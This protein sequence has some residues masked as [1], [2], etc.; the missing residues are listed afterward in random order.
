MNVRALLRP[1]FVHA[2][3]SISPLS[4]IP[5]L[6]MLSV[7]FHHVIR[8]VPFHLPPFSLLYFRRGPTISVSTR[9]SNLHSHVRAVPFFP[10]IFTRYL[11]ATT[12]YIC[13]L[14]SRTVCNLLPVPLCFSPYFFFFSLTFAIDVQNAIILHVSPCVTC[15][16]PPYICSPLI[17]S[18]HIDAQITSTCV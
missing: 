17:T 2:S 1:T 14:H 10:F 15:Y 8:L 9:F 16:F 18:S 13:S 11:R 6:L 4:R 7:C 12:S 5:P 3:F